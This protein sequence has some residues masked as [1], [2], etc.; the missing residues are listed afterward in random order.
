MELVNCT[1]KY[2][3]FV[4]ELRMDERVIDGFIKTTH[5]TSDM[6]EAYMTTHDKYYR[7]ALVDGKPAGYIG[8][9][10][11][12]IRVCTHPDYQ[13]KGVGKF[14]IEEA[15]KIW[16]TAEGKVKIGNEASMNLFKSC[17]FKEAY[18]IFKK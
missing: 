2:W 4:R 14:M 3:E 9:I 5:I 10:E 15:M 11:D 13:G 1:K 17:G 12:D 6:Q 7:I 18:I 16:P 8:V